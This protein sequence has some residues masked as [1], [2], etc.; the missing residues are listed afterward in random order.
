LLLRLTAAL[1]ALRALQNSSIVEI[2]KDSLF[3]RPK[4]TW[5]Q[6][7]RALDANLAAALSTCRQPISWPVP[8][9]IVCMPLGWFS[10]RASSTLK[11][12]I[13]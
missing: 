2:S 7:G 1:P 8:P 6:V 10:W 3:M 12:V 5:Q 11:W 9:A 13:Y 4:D